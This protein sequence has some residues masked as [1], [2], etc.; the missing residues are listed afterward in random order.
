[1]TAAAPARRIPWWHPVIDVLA[2]FTIV[3]LVVGLL[4]QWFAVYFTIGGTATPPTVSAITSYWVTAAITIA[5][6]LIGLVV[7]IMRRSVAG[8]I[9]YLAL[10]AL[11]ATAIVLFSVPQADWTQIVNDVRNPQYPVNTNYCSRT[12]SENCPGG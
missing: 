6:T 7:S 11:V 1:M 12:D 8:I 4:G 5:L 3:G 2:L 10:A 9:G